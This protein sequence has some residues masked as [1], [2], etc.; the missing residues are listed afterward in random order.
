MSANTKELITNVFRMYTTR[1]H[2]EQ[3]QLLQKY[4]APNVTFEDPLMRVHGHK[5]YRVQFHSLIKLFS[6]VKIDYDVSKYQ[7]VNPSST[8]PDAIDLII[9]NQQHY[10]FKKDGFISRRLFPDKVDLDTVTTITVVDGKI[11]S[12]RDVWI[13][14]KESTIHQK[15]T[16]PLLGQVVS[17]TLRLIGW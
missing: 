13:G 10:V 12:H 3:K 6:D 9:P 7:T 15:Y 14:N 1:S 5:N 11:V 8:R 16:K 17:V 2:D 4:F